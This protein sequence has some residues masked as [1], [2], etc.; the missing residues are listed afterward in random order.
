MP[1]AFKMGKITA[2]FNNRSKNQFDNYHPITVLLTCSKVLKRCIHS[3]LMNHFETHKLLSQDQFGFCSN[4]NTE[5]ADTIFVDFIVKNVDLGKLTGATFINL[6]KACDTLS[7]SQIIN[8]FCNYGVSNVGKKVF[9]KV[10]LLTT[11]LIE[12]S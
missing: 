9:I 5:V 6:S 8:N 11:F 2:T 4:R 10:L 3:Q 12:S 7:Y 1:K